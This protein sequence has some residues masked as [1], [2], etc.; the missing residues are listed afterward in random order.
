MRQSN[1]ITPPRINGTIFALEQHAI[2][3]KAL[4]FSQLLSDVSTPFIQQGWYTSALSTS[5]TIK[6]IKLNGDI[7]DS[8]ALTSTVRPR[9]AT[10]Y[11][12][13]LFLELSS[14]S[15]R[16]SSSGGR[17]CLRRPYPWNLVKFELLAIL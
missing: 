2:S 15:S 4:N 7:S 13:S 1:I 3:V 16:L 9:R 12:E 6:L 8:F 14:P 17:I 11:A 10:P 5:Q